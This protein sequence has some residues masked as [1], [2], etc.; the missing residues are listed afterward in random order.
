M[1]PLGPNGRMTASPSVEESLGEARP[2]VGGSA[3][4]DGKARQT[5]E[6]ILAVIP[7][8][9]EDEPPSVAPVLCVSP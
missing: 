4:G 2:L 7:A 5:A 3:V 9:K 8:S 1:M 6:R